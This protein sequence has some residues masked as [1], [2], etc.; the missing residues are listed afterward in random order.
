MIYDTII[1]GA[2]PAGITASVYAARK[3]MKI[4]IISEDIGGQVAKTSVVENYTGY[5][6]ITG[7][8][9]ARKFDDHMKEF[10]FDF[11][12]IKVRNLAKDNNIFTVETEKEKL[13]SKTLIIA[14]GA[15]PREL[16]AEG[17]KEFKNKGV[18]YCATCDAPLFAGKDVAVIG[19]GNS[20]LES[21]LQLT[22]IANKIYMVNKNENFRG[23]EILVK[24][25]KESPK[26]EIINN[27][28]TKAILGER[29]VEQIK[30]D[31][32]GQEIKLDV[33]G[34]F[35][36]IGYVPN[37]RIVENLV[38]LNSKGE[39]EIDSFGKTNVPGI[40]AAGD[41]TDVPYKQIITAAGAGATAALSAFKYL[42]KLNNQI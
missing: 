28:K 18:T 30:I 1:I 35:I 13:T 36:D 3:G 40:F 21:G 33:Q 5:Q 16:K 38:Q 27:A 25:I 19:G 42:S 29:F 39:I 22:N 9:L 8:Q 15:K 7:E 12:Q 24:K 31:K 6:E 4:V 10:K 17:E 37:T 23:D 11:K 41:C 14:T 26:V 2:G 20:A 32:G 34:V